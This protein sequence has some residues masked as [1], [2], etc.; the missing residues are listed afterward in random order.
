MT[1][2]IRA[3][4]ELEE[5]VD[6]F[7]ALMGAFDGLAGDNPPSWLPVVWEK[8]RAVQASL[9]PVSKLGRGQS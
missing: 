3:L 7:E 5:K 8:V 2:L 4:I 9:E 6:H 1:E